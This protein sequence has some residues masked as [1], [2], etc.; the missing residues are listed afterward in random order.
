MRYVAQGLSCLETLFVLRGILGDWSEGKERHVTTVRVSGKCFSPPL[1]TETKNTRRKL[2]GLCMIWNLHYQM[3]KHISNYV[4]QSTVTTWT[5]VE[6]F[7]FRITRILNLEHAIMSI[8]CQ[9]SG[10]HKTKKHSG[11]FLVPFYWCFWTNSSVCSLLL[12][13]FCCF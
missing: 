5:V 11:R 8:Y 3:S 10:G 1:K 13:F 2:K 12:S 9:L 4:V 6:M 7:L